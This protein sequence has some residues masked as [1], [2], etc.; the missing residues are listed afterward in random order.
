MATIKTLLAALSG[1]TVLV[2]GATGLIGKRLVYSLLEW[3]KLNPDA[4]IRVIV[5]A[6]RET[7]AR[8]LFGGIADQIQYLIGDIREISLSNLAV[9][10]VVHAA[11]STDSSQ[12]VNAPVE[13]VRT[14][15]EGTN[16]LLSELTNQREL[17]RL[18]FLSTMEV[19]GTPTTDD[20]ILET[21]GTNLN[22]MSIRASYP[23]A[24][25]MSE[26]LCACYSSEYGVDYSVLRLTQTFGPGVRYDDGR[27][28]AEFA[29]C[30]LECKDIVL[31]TKGETKRSYLYLDDAVS[32]IL[33]VLLRG[34][35]G[36]AYNAANPETY[37]SIYEMGELVA[38]E[39]MGGQICV[40]IKETHSPQYAPTLHMNLNTEKLEALGWKPEVGLKE[41]Y[42][43]LI[44]DLKQIA[45]IE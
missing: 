18:L 44:D 11:S 42:L 35:A 2:T 24:K 30:A 37:C 19:Y 28:F 40:R 22:S 20:P 6:R 36:E 9:N 10:Y 12:F 21:H 4:S 3:N 14:I 43:R 25:W 38:S 41:M 32:A 29:R 5:H 1:S 39:I 7:Y 26:N 23:I 27:V 33:T 15:T 45:P 31:A 17:K 13:T 8:A 34:K 16:R